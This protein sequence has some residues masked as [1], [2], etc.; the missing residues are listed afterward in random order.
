M[1]IVLWFFLTTLALCAALSMLLWQDW[2]R[3]QQTPLNPEGEV[4]LWIA[5]GSSF[6]ALVR[7]LERLGMARPTWHWRLLARLRGG[8][9]RAGEYR[10]APA[11]S[12]P[13]LLDHLARGGVRQHRLTIVEGWTLARLRRELAADPR[14]NPI[15][16]A[17]SEQE[18]M[19]QLDCGDCFAEGRFLP[20]TYFFERGSSD[21]DL[22][23]RAYQAMQ[24]LADRHWQERQAGLPLDSVEQL[25]ILASII[26]RETGQA[27]E[28]ARVAGVFIRRLQLGMRLQTDPTVIYGLGE[29]FQGRLRRIH[30]Q[31]DHPWNT[32]TRHGLPPTPIA[33]PGAR[34]LQAAA[35]PAAGTALFFVARGDGSHH[36][37]DTLAEHNAAVNRY[38]RGRR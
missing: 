11:S 29:D 16:S 31:T 13:A 19:E 32:Y 30:L 12:V 14:L 1:R 6:P 24:D 33:L 25:L 36:F 10:L 9:L 21:F 22:L 20:E 38:I 2:Q 5:P 37:S 27:D 17:W 28:R 26:E 8:E 23:R 35:H 34:S 3:F 15:T 7:D 4:I 18:L